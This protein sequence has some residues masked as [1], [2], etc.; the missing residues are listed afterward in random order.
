L[1]KSC[2]SRI[3]RLAQMALGLVEAICKG[4]T[5]WRGCMRAKAAAA[6]AR[7]K[8]EGEPVEDS[9]LA[10]VKRVA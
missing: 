6:R 4:G 8:S 10:E 1:N 5:I 9:F 3:L 2:V 7:P